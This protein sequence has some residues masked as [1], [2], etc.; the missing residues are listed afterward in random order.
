M[1]ARKTL[2]TVSV[3]VTAGVVL[4]GCL[5]EK[6]NR[7]TKYEPGVYKGRADSKL[8]PAQRRELARRTV[9]QSGPAT[10][11]GGGAARAAAASGSVRTPSEALYG[12]L[13]TRAA[14]Q[15]GP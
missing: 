15:K 3:L 4:A 11:A 10:T 2:G 7:I 1:K 8:T 6:R 12:R 14:N 13:N 5:D 9:R